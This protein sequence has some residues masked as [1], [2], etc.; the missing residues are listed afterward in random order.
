[1]EP[2]LKISTPSRNTR[3]PGIKL[4]F[5]STGTTTNKGQDIVRVIATQHF[6][7]IARVAPDMH[8]DYLSLPRAGVN[9]SFD[10]TK[11]D[12]MA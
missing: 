1:M 3:L 8:V 12:G 4:A 7:D 6:R 9:R 5:S 2:F 10:L 11:H